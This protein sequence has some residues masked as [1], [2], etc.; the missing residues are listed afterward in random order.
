MGRI[1]VLGHWMYVWNNE[2]AISDFEEWYLPVWRVESE[3]GWGLED[4]LRITQLDIDGISTTWQYGVP[5]LVGDWEGPIGDND[6]AG[7]REAGR[8]SKQ[9]C[10]AINQ[11]WPTQLWFIW[12]R[13]WRRDHIDVN[14]FPAIE[15]NQTLHSSVVW[16]VACQVSKSVS[17]TFWY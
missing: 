16:L 2:G 8:H 12:N 1:H 3:S 9:Y 13:S 15:R 11:S 17:E 7:L 6:F 5:V 14:T 4:L 10:Q